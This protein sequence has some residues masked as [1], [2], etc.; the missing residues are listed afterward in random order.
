PCP[1]VGIAE[2]KDIF[3]GIGMRSHPYPTKNILG[4]CNSNFWT[5]FWQSVLL[6]PRNT[7][8]PISW[9]VFHPFVPCRDRNISY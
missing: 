7:F 6:Y 2:S 9:T 1:K 3:C 5:G 4:F 8:L